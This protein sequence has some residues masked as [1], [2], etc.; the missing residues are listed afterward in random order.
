MILCHAPCKKYYKKYPY[1]PFPVES[2]LD[3]Y[4]HERLNAEVVVRTIENKQAAVNYL[5]WT[6]MY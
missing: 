1:D 6:F 4:L 5:T 2:H 3:D